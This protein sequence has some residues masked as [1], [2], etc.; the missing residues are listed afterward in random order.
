MEKGCFKM[1]KNVL[2]IVDVISTSR[3][4]IEYKCVE[5]CTSIIVPVDLKDAKG[6]IDYS[7]I[8]R[9]IEDIRQ[10][11]KNYLEQAFDSIN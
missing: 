11:S 6:E 3:Q 4:L 2:N 7:I 8:D 5:R 1:K 10:E 9:K